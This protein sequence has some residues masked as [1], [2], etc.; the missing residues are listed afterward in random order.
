MTTE[1]RSVKMSCGLAGIESGPTRDQDLLADLFEMTE[2]GP[3]GR[4]LHQ[5]AA[6]GFEH[7]R[8]VCHDTV[9][10]HWSHLEIRVIEVADV[11]LIVES[12]GKLPGKIELLIELTETSAAHRHLK[13]AP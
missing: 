8:V 6:A 11:T 3:G 13:P 12:L 5:D 2:I 7:A 10:S 4:Q 9:D 1:A